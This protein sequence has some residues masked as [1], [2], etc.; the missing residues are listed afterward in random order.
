MADRFQTAQPLESRFKLALP[1]H[2][3][4]RTDAATRPQQFARDTASGPAGLLIPKGNAHCG[5]RRSA[6]QHRRYAI[7]FAGDQ[8]KRVVELET[9]EHS[10]L[11]QCTDVLL[12][13]N[14]VMESHGRFLH[15]FLS[16]HF[17]LTSRSYLGEAV[18][19]GVA[20]LV[21][22]PIPISEDKLSALTTTHFFL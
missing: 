18:L 3:A 16:P 11:L 21:P 20:R 22:G 6:S 1:R 17:P 4:C 12:F 9:S 13:R 19:A 2:L 7:G 14:S 10:S 5:P 8:W 15:S